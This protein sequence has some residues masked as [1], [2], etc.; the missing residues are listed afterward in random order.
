MTGR[1]RF[2]ERYG[3]GILLIHERQDHD[4]YA[5]P[6]FDS[7][8]ERQMHSKWIE[9]RRTDVDFHEKWKEFHPFR[10]FYGGGEP[11]LVCME[12]RGEWFR[13]RLKE[14]RDYWVRQEDRTSD[15]YGRVENYKRFELRSWNEFM[16]GKGWVD[17]VEAKANPI[18]HRPHENAKTINYEPGDCLRATRSRRQWLAVEPH[19][20]EGCITDTTENEEI[21]KAL[22]FKRGWIKWRSDSIFLVRTAY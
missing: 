5:L 7:I 3:I 8:G 13:V 11:F 12:R 9:L 4:I 22:F 16:A 14:S 19:N 15:W 2:E 21:F 10:I 1:D 18:R 17:R 20:G 6:L